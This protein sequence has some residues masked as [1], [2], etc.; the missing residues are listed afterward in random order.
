MIKTLPLARLINPTLDEQ[1]YRQYLVQASR[2][3][4]QQIILMEN[5]IPR[6]MMGIRPNPHIDGNYLYFSDT[7]VDPNYR[8]QGLGKQLLDSM[9]R[10][11]RTHHFEDVYGCASHSADG[12]YQKYD[13]HDNGKWFIK[14]L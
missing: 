5:N 13:Y 11:A 8:N 14:R 6:A 10:Y 2:Y 12:Y 3:D 7:V 9:E 1:G 4:Y